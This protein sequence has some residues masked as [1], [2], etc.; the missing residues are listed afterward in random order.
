MINAVNAALDNR[1]VRFNG[2]RR[3]RQAV[4]VTDIFFR[5]VVDG[6]VSPLF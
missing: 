6:I 2:V 5:A 4:F 3:D 1:E